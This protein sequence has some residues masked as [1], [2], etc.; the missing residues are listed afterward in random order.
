MGMQADLGVEAL[1]H[2]A[3]AVRSI[4]AALPL[5]RDRSAGGPP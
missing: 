2:T 5:Y 1:D 4:Q 3:V